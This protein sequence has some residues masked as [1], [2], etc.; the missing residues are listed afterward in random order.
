MALDLVMKVPCTFSERRRFLSQPSEDVARLYRTSQKRIMRFLYAG[1]A[2]ISLA[3]MG[4]CFV[5]LEGRSVFHHI[6]QSMQ[7]GL[8]VAMVLTYSFILPT[9]SR[10]IDRVVE[11]HAIMEFLRVGF[12]SK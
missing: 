3:T 2:C 4:F 7:I 1:V 6:A 8:G 12:L 9:L 11:K 5:T 10:C